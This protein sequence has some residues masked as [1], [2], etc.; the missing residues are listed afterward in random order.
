MNSGTRFG[1]GNVAVSRRDQPVKTKEFCRHHNSLGKPPRCLI[2]SSK[3]FSNGRKN[4]VR[5]ILA[6]SIRKK[7]FT[8]S[9]RQKIP[10]S[11][12]STAFAFAHWNGSRAVEEQVK[13]DLK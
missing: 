7:N 4:S 6:R 12:K 8:I 10:K 5:Q 13:N 11:R 2:P 3:I 1:I 9:S